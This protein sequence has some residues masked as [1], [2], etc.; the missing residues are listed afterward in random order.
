MGNTIS[1]YCSFFYLF[2]SPPHA[3]GIPLLVTLNLGLISV[4]PHMRGEYYGTHTRDFVTV[5][6]PPHAWGI[7]YLPTAV[8]QLFT[9]HP[10]M[11]GEYASAQIALSLIR[12][13]PPHAWGILIACDPMTGVCRFTPTC[14]GNTMRLCDQ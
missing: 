10:H 9:V 6:S 12:G 13:S 4:H 7:Q 8:S 11:R 1:P 5:G 2:G 14:V 3:W